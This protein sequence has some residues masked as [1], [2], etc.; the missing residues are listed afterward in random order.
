[1]VTRPVRRTAA[2]WPVKR[3][4]ISVEKWNGMYF[5]WSMKVDSRGREKSPRNFTQHCLTGR[6]SLIIK[7]RR[8]KLEGWLECFGQDRG[9]IAPT[10]R[11]GDTELIF[12][13]LF[14]S[15]G[16]L[17]SRGNRLTVRYE[18]ALSHF[19]WFQ[20]LRCER[21][22][23]G[24]PGGVAKGGGGLESGR[25]NHSED[26]RDRL[27]TEYLQWTQTCRL[28]LRAARVIQAGPSLFSKWNNTERKMYLEL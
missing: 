21:R 25:G 2:C 6:Q 17:L 23:S 22:W 15:V 4:D 19:I 3:D 20:A 7:T 24:V 28:K 27:R 11:Q 14:I 26:E 10:W 1:M 13:S 16:D 5:D 12:F 9:I 8:E 18:R